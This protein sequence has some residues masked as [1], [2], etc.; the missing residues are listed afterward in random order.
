MRHSHARLPNQN[1]NRSRG[2]TEEETP[3]PEDTLT[4][5]TVEDPLEVKLV[6]DLEV[7]ETE[8][9]GVKESLEEVTPEP[10]KKV[11]PEK[12]V[13]ATETPEKP[14]EEPKPEPVISK[15]KTEP[16]TETKKKKTGLEAVAPETPPKE[17]PSRANPKVSDKIIVQASTQDMADSIA[18][19][20]DEKMATET[21]P[22]KKTGLEAVAPAPTSSPKEIEIEAKKAEPE[23]TEAQKEAGNYK[24]GHIKVAGF[25]VTIENAKGSKRSGIGKDGE[26]WEVRMPAHYGYIRRTEGADGEQ[27]DIY[28]GDDLDSQAVYVF[29]QYDADTQEFDE[30]KVMMGFSTLDDAKQAYDAAFDDGRGPE[31]RGKVTAFS[32]PDYF[33]WLNQED[34]TKPV[35]EAK[36]GEENYRS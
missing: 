21:K 27:I 11:K 14:K 16:V 8:L 17:K 20:I 12:T 9:E 22:A 25:D 34:T 28:V 33:K 1:Q 18:G 32:N 19:A 6:D 13:T 36:I 24:K 23:P 10:E 30:H 35:A 26:K 3:V 2:V 15:T 4:E 7:A 5:V 29:D 31:R